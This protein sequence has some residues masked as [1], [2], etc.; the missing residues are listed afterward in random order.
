MSY[1]VIICLMVFYALIRDY[2]RSSP[3]DEHLTPPQVTRLVTHHNRAP[4][5]ATS[6]SP[7]CLIYRAPLTH[8]NRAPLVAKRVVE[9]SR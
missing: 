8:H 4:R 7:S 3:R 9:K 6:R 5:T 1:G 2:E